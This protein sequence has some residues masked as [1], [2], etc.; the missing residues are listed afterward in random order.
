MPELPRTRSS[1]HV[2]R[3]C[4]RKG[5]G[6][7]GRVSEREKKRKEKKDGFVLDAAPD[8]SR[9]SKV[10]G[11]ILRRNEEV[12]GKKS[13]EKKAGEKRE[14][15]GETHY[16]PYTVHQTHTYLACCECGHIIGYTH[17]CSNART[18]A[19]AQSAV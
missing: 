3:V 1:T 10:L 17:I 15:R 4:A 19:L 13:R 8:S 9:R 11:L 5:G 2:L 14:R 18:R 16:T 6:G 7:G 12:L